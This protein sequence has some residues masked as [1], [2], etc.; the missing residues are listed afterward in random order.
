MEGTARRVAVFIGAGALLAALVGFTVWATSSPGQNNRAGFTA[1]AAGTAGASATSTASS[2]TTATV[3]ENQTQTRTV[4]SATN[5]A[6]NNGGTDRAAGTAGQAGPGQQ[7]PGASM[8]TGYNAAHDPYLP[9]HAVVAP[10]PESGQPSRV[11]R[12]SNIVPS[13]ARPMTAQDTKPA[14]E[15]TPAG[16]QTS[17]RTPSQQTPDSTPSRE[18]GE[19]SV[20]QT[21]TPA[22]PAPGGS[23]AQ[24]SE[25]AEPTHPPSAEPSKQPEQS[26]TTEASDESEQD[27]QPGRGAGPS[28]GP[29]GMDGTY[30]SDSVEGVEGVEGVDGTNGVQDA[31]LSPSD[32]A[33][34]HGATMQPSA[35]AGIAESSPVP[36]NTSQ[37]AAAKTTPDAAPTHVEGKEDVAGYPQ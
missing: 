13:S 26:P 9:P 19:S 22:A 36:Q 6:D 3:T 8:P 5:S 24:P 32:P 7:R 31:A 10:A 17:A 16:G 12:P 11:Y 14:A 4:R 21:S 23:E 20:G 2:P 28:H 15:P 30:G 18:P 35:G 33:S 34:A 29:D 37:N 1:E 27:P 25:A